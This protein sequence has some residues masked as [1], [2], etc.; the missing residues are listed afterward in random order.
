M[1]NPI[2]F[3]TDLWRQPLWIPLWVTWLMGLNFAGAAF[4]PD[5]LAQLIVVTFMLSAG[6]MMALYSVF[7]FVKLLGLGHIL[8]VPLAWR[9]LT[10]LPNTSGAFRIYL[11]TWGMATLVSLVFDA[12]DVWKYFRSRK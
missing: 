8:W 12:V 4:W 11:V 9:V 6:L 1:R 2:G 5:P 7:G 3:F 10:Q